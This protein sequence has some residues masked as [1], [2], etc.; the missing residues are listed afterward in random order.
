MNS[1]V[2][3]GHTGG[4]GS[5]LMSKYQEKGWTVFGASRRTGYDF[6]QPRVARNFCEQLRGYDVLINT[7]TGSAQRNVLEHMHTQWRDQKKIILNVGSRATQYG[8][9]PSISYSADKA[10]LDFVVSSL[11]AHGPRWPA[12]LH[13]RPG[14]FDSKR[15]EL[16]NVPKMKTEDVAD[17][18]MFMID[19]VHK[20]RIL[21][22]ILVV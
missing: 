9:S 21:D 1:V 6:S 17:M 8:A 18:I 22:M 13:I 12:I 4:L 14:F 10:A 19:N 3:T 20:F 2:I 11:Q 16:K 15:V 7:I 5:V